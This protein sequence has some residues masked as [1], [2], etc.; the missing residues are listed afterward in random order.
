MQ[1]AFLVTSMIDRDFPARCCFLEAQCDSLQETVHRQRALLEMV[2]DIPFFS[3][4]KGLR[5]KIVRE[6]QRDA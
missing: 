5:E 2:L 3:Q 4:F 6:L 1:G